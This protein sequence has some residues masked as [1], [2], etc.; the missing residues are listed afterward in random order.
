MPMAIAPDVVLTT[1]LRFFSGL[2]KAG[3]P[4]PWLKERERIEALVEAIL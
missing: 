3:K 1:F 4:V 2:D